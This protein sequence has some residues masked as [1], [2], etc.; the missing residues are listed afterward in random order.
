MYKVL[1]HVLSRGNVEHRDKTE[2]GELPC[3]PDLILGHMNNSTALEL[4]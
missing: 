3:G 1:A 4:F 2:S